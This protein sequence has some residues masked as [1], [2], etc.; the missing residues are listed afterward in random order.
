MATKIETPEQMNRSINRWL[1]QVERPSKR[2]YPWAS[3]AKYIREVTKQRFKAHKSPGGS[4]WK[5]K[6]S[7]KVNVGER[8]DV[9]VSGTTR[10]V[11]YRRVRNSKEKR[12]LNN[13]RYPNGSK[14]RHG[15]LKALYRPAGK[16]KA[17]KLF[18][19]YTKKSGHGA[20]QRTPG[21]KALII[22]S[23]FKGAPLMQHGGLGKNKERV[24]PRPFYALNSTDMTEIVN[25]IANRVMKELDKN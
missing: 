18:T 25:I 12:R 24:T 15:N 21:N 14:R 19:A 16:Y 20:V 7:N 8:T 13:A 22:G 1:S 6:K 17:K 10:K 3:V 9:A 4:A 5:P 2:F 11:I 23:W